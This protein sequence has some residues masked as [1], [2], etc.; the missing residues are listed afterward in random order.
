VR[1]LE[2]CALLPVSCMVTCWFPAVFGI[3]SVERVLIEV[4]VFRLAKTLYLF[5]SNLLFANFADRVGR[6]EC[7]FDDKARQKAKAT[8][9]ELTW[10]LSCNFP[11]T[12]RHPGVC[13]CEFTCCV[14]MLY[15]THPL[16]YKGQNSNE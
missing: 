6:R 2:A 11:C 12:A 15:C 13:R 4:A 9:D 8:C 5:L 3:L 7:R 16:L 10:S 14:S 1:V